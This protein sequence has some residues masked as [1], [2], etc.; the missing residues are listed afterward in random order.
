MNKPTLLLLLLAALFCSCQKTESITDLRCENLKNPLA[1]DNTSPHFSWKLKA[2]KQIAYRLLV[3]SD[4][5]ALAKGE[6]DLWNSGK[7]NSSSSVMVPYQGKA[8]TSPSLAYW[9]VQVWHDEEA[10]PR[11][12]AIARFGVGLLEASDWKGAYIGMPESDD[13]NYSTPLLRKKFILDTKPEVTFLH[14]NSLGFHEVY[15]NGLKVTDDVL[16]PAVSQLNKRSLSVT[17]DVTDYLNQGEND[18]IMWIGKGWYRK[19]TFEATYDGPLVKVQME[20]L[21]NKEWKTELVSDKSWFGSSSAYSDAGSVRWHA[22]EFGGERLDGRI[23]TKDFSSASFD[24]HSWTQAIEVE[25][26]EHKVSPQMCEPNRI[27]EVLAPASIRQLGADTWLID[28]GKSLTGWFSFE[29]PSMEE[30]TEI[31]LLYCDMLNEDGDIT[32]RMQ[33]DIYIAAGSDKETFCNKFNYHAFRYVKISNLK[34]TP[35]EEYFKAH[36]IY[37]DYGDASSFECSDA[38][39]NAIHDMVKYTIKCLTLG[40]YMVDCPHIERLGYGGD[41]HSAAKTFYTMYDASS[42]FAN[43]LQAWEDCSREDG[44][45]PHTAPSPYSAGGGPYWSAFVIQAPWTAYVNYGDNRFLER[46]YPVMQK[47][48][49]HVQRHMVDGVLRPWPH[50]DYR[51]WYLGDWACPGPIDQT[52]PLS[53]DV[54]NNCVISECLATMEKIA[55]TLGKTADADSYK[56]QKEALDRQI[57]KVFYDKDKNIYGTGSQSNLSYPLLTGVVAD[58]LM[59]SITE[60]LYNEIYNACEGHVSGGIVGIPVLVDWAVK[61]NDPQVIYTMLK[62]RDFPGFLYMIDNGATTVWE[63]W[64]GERSRIHNCYNGIGSWFYSAIGG[65]RPSE[66]F[67]GYKQVII[68]PQIPEGITWARANKETAYGTVSVNWQLEN[69]KLDLQITIPANSTG[70]FI[71]PPGT[72]SGLLNGCQIDTGQPVELENGTH[73]LALTI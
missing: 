50:T 38:D 48:L 73:K 49:G 5:S 28:M 42:L 62:K 29:L 58:S 3:A 55:T 18:L 35:K 8:L 13:N 56:K 65:I 64:N 6:A 14:V 24:R 33:Q 23:D 12:S 54:V 22:H 59:P 53:I 2:G 41:G 34:I 37:T 31:T 51:G 44:D 16:S 10:E 19:T 39:M 52:N 71:C 63:H 25:V 46:Y 4:S 36:L 27:K 57:H 47:W 70:S 66:E 45:L 30:G 67:P 26:P 32:D 7:V 43:W 40:G 72:K 69:K 9:S 21:R 20:T 15:L 1:I 68:Q 17:Y 11:S 61:N 60:Q